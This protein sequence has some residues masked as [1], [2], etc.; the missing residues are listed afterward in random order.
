M[1]VPTST[2]APPPAIRRTQLQRSEITQAALMR[3][4]VD[5]LVEDGYARATTARICAR[6]G[7]SRGAHLHHF[8]TRDRLLTAAVAHL[9][10]ELVAP[11]LD[12][13]TAAGAGTTDDDRRGLDT[14]WA[15]YTGPLFAAVLDVMAATRTDP[16]LAEQLRPVEREVNQHTLLL[17]RHLF[18]AH[19]GRAGFERQMTFVLST[20]RGLAM[21]DLINAT[22]PHRERRW[23]EVRA[24]LLGHLAG[25][26]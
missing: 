7:L 4:A 24:T 9:A 26:D 21:L 10:Q 12:E 25:A 18:P 8:G 23:H 5:V 11:F 16:A 6:A 17:C 14:I 22:S 20:I 1:G 13:A 15:L 3:A 2:S 19:A